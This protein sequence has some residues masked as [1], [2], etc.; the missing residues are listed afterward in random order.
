MAAFL[1]TP[2][3]ICLLN[4]KDEGK[5]HNQCHSRSQI[6]IWR[7][8][9]DRSESLG[10]FLCGL[11][12]PSFAT[13]FV[14]QILADLTIQI[15]NFDEKEDGMVSIV[16]S[17]AEAEGRELLVVNTKTFIEK[18]TTKCLLEGK[19]VERTAKGGRKKY[20][21]SAFEEGARLTVQCELISRGEGWYTHQSWVVNEEGF[22][23][24]QMRLKRP[25]EEDVV[26]HRTYRRI[27]GP[28][29]SGNGY[30]EAGEDGGSSG[31]SWGH[32]MPIVMAGVVCVGLWFVCKRRGASPKED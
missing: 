30:T 4:E 11:G 21:L 17:L 3:P 31:G 16:E 9:A 12:M 23:Q 5:Q 2:L 25:N 14:D 1:L 19:E 32:A 10:P 18:S 24:E 13:I 7:Q 6:G 8:D 26:V 22:L 15:R 27:D 28:V 29:A 20:L